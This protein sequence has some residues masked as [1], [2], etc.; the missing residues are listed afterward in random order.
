[1]KYIGM[2]MGMWVVFAG[3]FRRLR[4]ERPGPAD[5]HDEHHGDPQRTVTQ[6]S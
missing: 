3:A 4:P 2:P 5:L 1:M 6:H